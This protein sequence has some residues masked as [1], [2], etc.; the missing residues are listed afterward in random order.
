MLNIVKN[1][2]DT[3]REFKLLREKLVYNIKK[4]D[5]ALAK[6]QK[7]HHVQSWI[8]EHLERRLKDAR[9]KLVSLDTLLS[10]ND[11]GISL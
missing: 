8:A 6:Y 1:V 2:N 9:D 11:Q 5:A 3:D 7:E 4:A 10:S